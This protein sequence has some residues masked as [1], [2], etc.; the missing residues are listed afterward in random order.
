[1]FTDVGWAG[2][3]PGRDGQTFA[4]ARVGAGLFDRLLTV[5]VARDVTAGP[6]VA[7]SVNPLR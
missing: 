6:Q 5:D 2:E 7:V 3:R 1:V 4:F